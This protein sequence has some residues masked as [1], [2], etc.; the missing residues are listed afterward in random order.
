M[1]KRERFNRWYSTGAF[2]TAFI[3]IDLPITFLCTLCYVSL[4]YVMTN[5]PHEVQRFLAF[6]CVSLALSYAAQGVGL[7]GSALLDVKVKELFWK[8]KS[9][10]NVFFLMQSAAIF[11]GIFLS[12]FFTFS[13]AAILM[14][15]TS[16]YFHWLFH[17]NFVDNAIKGSVQAI[18]GMNRTKIECDALYCHYSYPSKVLQEVEASV[19][20]ERSLMVLV[21]Y[22]VFSRVIT[23]IFIKY[24]LK[25]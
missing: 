21:A 7:M 4:T 22:A 9:N 1:I 20:V 3:V 23:F 17:A 5:Q 13:S 8:V 10:L 6:F 2:F 14:K 16:T 18:F 24:R 15:D 25:S 11:S 12:P 19:S